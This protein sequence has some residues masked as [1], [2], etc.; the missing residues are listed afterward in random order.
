MLTARTIVAALAVGLLAGAL[1]AVWS[2]LA[3]VLD[4]SPLPTRVV[5]APL[6]SPLGLPSAAAVA[7]DRRAG[8]A[9]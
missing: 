4:P 7:R 9:E 3:S 6:S 8:A 2:S 5:A 1:C